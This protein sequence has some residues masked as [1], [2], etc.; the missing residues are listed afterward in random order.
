L[1][2]N[3]V[4]CKCSVCSTSEHTLI[5]LVGIAIGLHCNNEMLALACFTAFMK[6]CDYNFK[7]KLL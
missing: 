7:P 3:E 1:C 6:Q 4:F 5:M 2:K